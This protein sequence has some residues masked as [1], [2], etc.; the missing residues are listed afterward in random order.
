M[1]GALGSPRRMGRY[2]QWI[3]LTALTGSPILSLLILLVFWFAVDRFTLGLLPDPVRW[4]MRLRRTW[5][6]E[7]TLTGNPH[8]RRS[9][10]ELAELYIGQR[11][12][13][14]AVN[15]L[16]PNLEAGDDDAPTL[17]AM[18]LACYGAGH[19][20]QAEVFLG[21]AEEHDPGFR[22]GAIELERGRWRLR[23]GDP[24]GAREALERFVHQR[25]G[26]IE[27]RVLL[28]RA[29]LA[30]GNEPQAALMQEE[31]WK[32]Y[33]SAPRFQRRVERFWAWR[34]K[35]WRPV[36]YAAALLLAGAAFGR[37]VAPSL[38]T[39]AGSMRGGYGRSYGYRAP[40]SS[41]P[42]DDEP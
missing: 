2:F 3:I 36:A 24:K 32:E 6:L 42:P 39:A 20:E 34:A 21:A 18:G 27:G 9:R 8:D 4:V 7:R 35:P 11:R 17:F 12:Y 37:F 40:P 14:N 16:K 31:A 23:H 30:E 10:F 25:K 1:E 26:T 33:V 13:K 19:F 29:M 41:P 28:G 38:M 15:V 22:L 5:Q